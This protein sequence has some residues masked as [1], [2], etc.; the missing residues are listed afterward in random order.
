MVGPIFLNESGNIE[1]WLE[2]YHEL[3]HRQ[4]DEY[5]KNK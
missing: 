3:L 5:K 1:K 4:Y 2:N